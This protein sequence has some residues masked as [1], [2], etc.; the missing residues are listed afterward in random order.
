MYGNNSHLPIKH[1]Y[2]HFMLDKLISMQWR[3]CRIMWLLITDKDI[4]IL[5][6]AYEKGKCEIS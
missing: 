4:K 1:D 2:N 6:T 3:N 5:T